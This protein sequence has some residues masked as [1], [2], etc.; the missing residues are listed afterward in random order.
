[1]THYELLSVPS[2]SNTDEIRRAYVRATRLCGAAREEAASGDAYAAAQRAM[3]D[4]DIAW[5][6][7]SDPA[8]RRAYDAGL[9]DAQRAA[10]SDPGTPRMARAGPELV[11]APEWLRVRLDVVRDLPAARLVM[12]GALLAGM[13]VVTA[14]VLVLSQHH[15][16]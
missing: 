6:T 11:P 16:L 15:L 12:G 3:S 8:R 4:A 1:V 2:S 14:I 9:K 13:V 7:L 5:A 10:V